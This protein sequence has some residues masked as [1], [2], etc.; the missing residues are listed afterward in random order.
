MALL[1]TVSFGCYVAGLGQ[2]LFGGLSL[3]LA[4]WTPFFV[5]RR[6]RHFRDVG[7][8][9]VISMRR[10]WGFVVL[11]FFYA[12]VLLALA[13][14][15]YFAYLDKGFMLGAIDQMLHAPESVQML[16][17]YGMSESLEASLSQMRE[18]RPIDI[19]INVLTTNILIGI[20]LG[21][22]IAALSQRSVKAKPDGQA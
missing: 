2:P 22:P 13:Q 10:G 12:S 3:L 21:L 15:A 17:Q 1:W 8:D 19:A 20:F 7:R 18:M 5:A 14:Y 4:L 16:R 9:G 11:T 6:L